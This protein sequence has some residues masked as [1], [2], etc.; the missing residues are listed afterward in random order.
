[1]LFVISVMGFVAQ[2]VTVRHKF[3]P[4]CQQ[5]SLLGEYYFTTGKL[6]NT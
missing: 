3:E 2:I 1:M 5:I 6:F 4:L